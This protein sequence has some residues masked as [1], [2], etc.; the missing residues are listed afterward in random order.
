MRGQREE[1]G[2]ELEEIN[3]SILGSEITAIME[4]ILSTQRQ[5]K[6]DEAVLP[7]KVT[8]ISSNAAASQ[9]VCLSKRKLYE[10][11]QN[12]ILQHF[13]SKKE[14]SI[15]LTLG[16]PLNLYPIFSSTFTVC[17]TVKVKGIDLRN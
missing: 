13:L 14:N 1:R 2:G 7:G 5:E 4:D 3:V 10:I 16:T 9:Q 17:C 11:L 12:I 8:A 15:Y 6:K